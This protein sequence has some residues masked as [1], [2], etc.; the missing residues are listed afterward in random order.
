MQVGGIRDIIR[1]VSVRA[2]LARAAAAPG[3]AIM[4]VERATGD[5]IDF[6]SGERD[7][8]RMAY[9]REPPRRSSASARAVDKPLCR[10][11]L[12]DSLGFFIYGFFFS[13]ALSRILFREIVLS[14]FSLRTDEC[15]YLRSFNT[16]KEEE[17]LVRALWKLNFLAR[18]CRLIRRKSGRSKFVLC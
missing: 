2:A 4:N 1:C 10:E 9:A 12:R 8:G 6:A 18:R 3:E 14:F 13:F 7:G 11:Y 16:W 5:R 15:V 17:I